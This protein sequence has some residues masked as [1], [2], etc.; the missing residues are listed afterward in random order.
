[1]IPGDPTQAYCERDDE[2]PAPHVV[3]ATARFPECSRN[4]PASAARRRCHA[5]ALLVAR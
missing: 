4:M 1:M 3:S 2:S 5:Q